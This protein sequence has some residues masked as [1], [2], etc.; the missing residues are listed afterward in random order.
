M[1]LNPRCFFALFAALALNL[2]AQA[3]Q[4]AAGPM[5]GAPEMRSMPLWVQT[6]G[7]AEVAFAY[8]PEDQDTQRK[9]TSAQTTTPENGFVAK[10]TAGP[11][12][13]GTVYRYEVL[14]DGKKAAGD[15]EMKFKT[16]PYYTDRAPPPDF[17]VALGGGHIVNDPAYDPLNRTP[18]GGYEIFL[19]IL[20]KQPDL[21]IW[22]GNNVHLREPDW[23]SR[24]GM[25]ARYS[26][27]RAQPELQPL[28]AAVPQAATVSQGEIGPANTG[29]HFRNL[30]DAQSV[31]ELFWANPPSARS[32]D[33][34]ATS[35]RYGDAEFFLLDDRSNRS[36]D[37]DVEKNRE[38]MGEA[39]LAWLR[40]ALR[41]STAD[42]KII[43]TGSSA[44]SPS[45]SQL[46]HKIAQHERDGMLDDL[47][48][49]RISG[50]MFVNGGKD[51]GEFTKMVRAN[52][53]DLYELSLG[54]LTQRPADA[55][56]ELNF[57]RVPSS[58]TFQRQFAMLKFHGA[59]SD[60][61]LT[62]TV[63]NGLG[64]QLWTQTL[65]LS[66]MQYN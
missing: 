50:L 66:D 24:A 53:P 13:P 62:V 57:F 54:P 10:A 34:L 31:F 40:Q 27:S 11:L 3:P 38:I 42:F 44:L 60:R 18:G 8:W 9:V 5:V 65:A 51:F 43:V 30:A 35:I 37:F 29:K 23:G 20:A 45:D 61:Q 36:L 16:T 46:N 15:A 64:D 28:L 48:S 41:E 6:D 1:S 19:A 4:I 25:I 32:A 21:M 26:K 56:R 39:Q 59:E 12:E 55:T 22:A 14:L 2:S 33:G 47:K 58:S 7:P 49:D 52:A 17:T 63:Y